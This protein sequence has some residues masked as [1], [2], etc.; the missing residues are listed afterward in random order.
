MYYATPVE[1]KS[2]DKIKLELDFTLFYHPDSSNE[3]VIHYSLYSKKTIEKIS[4][5]SFLMPSKIIDAKDIPK[6]LFV[7]QVKGKWH[8]RYESKINLK[9]YFDLLQNSLLVNDIKLIEHE[10]SYEFEPNK[11]FR[12]GGQIIYEIIKAELS[13]K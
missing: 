6:L 9:E 3:V 10:H 4:Q 11:K 7:E 2:K 8:Y 12:E 1:L 13:L 5:L